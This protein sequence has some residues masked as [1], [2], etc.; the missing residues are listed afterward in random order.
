[1]SKHS[2]NEM[3]EN[4][5]KTLNERKRDQATFEAWPFAN[6]ADTAK[7]LAELVKKGDKT[8]T[9]S[10]YRMYEIGNEPIP[11]NGQYNVITD[12]DGNAEVIVQTTKVDVIPFNEVPKSF[13]FKEGEGDKSYEYWHRVHVDFFTN[14]LEVFN[15]QFHEDMLVVCEE[16]EVVYPK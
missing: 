4:F 1:M 8:A 14:E 2:V 12:W 7:E 11:T 5:L 10:L 3:W 9:C 15:E 13:A 16:F 6:D